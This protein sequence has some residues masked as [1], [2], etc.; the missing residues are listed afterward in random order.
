MQ[1][2]GVLRGVAAAVD[3]SVSESDRSLSL[4]R[5][6]ESGIKGVH[7]GQTLLTL[8]QVSLSTM[9]SPPQQSENRPRKEE[10]P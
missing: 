8:D 5:E 4:E 7:I 10:H 2:R 1:W 3:V 9:Q 6:K